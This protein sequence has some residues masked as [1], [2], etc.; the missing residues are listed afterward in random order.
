MRYVTACIASVCMVYILWCDLCIAPSWVQ[1]G[2]V[3]PLVYTMHSIEQHH[4]QHW[5]VYYYVV[6]S[7][8]MSTVVASNGMILSVLI[9]ALLHSTGWLHTPTWTTKKILADTW[10][11]VGPSHWGYTTIIVVSSMFSVGYTVVLLGANS[12]E[13]YYLVWWQCVCAYVSIEHPRCSMPQ[14]Q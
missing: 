8:S 11:V 4:E 10:W 12:Y 3:H 13:T 5:Y 7:I 9:S 1:C 2:S 6:H 14:V